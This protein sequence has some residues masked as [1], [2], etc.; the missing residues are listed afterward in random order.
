MKIIKCIVWISLL[1][2]QLAFSQGVVSQFTDAKGYYAR[3]GAIGLNQSHL[4]IGNHRI[5]TNKISIGLPGAP[6]PISPTLKLNPLGGNITM[7]NTITDF[8]ALTIRSFNE[9][10]LSK[11][12]HFEGDG[13][14]VTDGKLY[15]QIDSDNNEGGQI[16]FYNHNETLFRINEVGNSYLKGNFHV[17]GK[18][19]AD[20]VKS[21]D[22]HTIGF[23]DVEALNDFGD[24]LYTSS[25]GY[26]YGDN[27]TGFYMYQLGAALNLPHQ[28]KITKIEVIYKD[29]NNEY[30]FGIELR[31]INNFSNSHTT[32]Y[33]RS[34]T[35]SYS[36]SSWQKFSNNVDIDIDNNNSIYY[37]AVVSGDWGNNIFLGKSRFIIH[38]KDICD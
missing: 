8:A 21:S 25:N 28:A 6:P 31:K 35:D 3:F 26:A 32:I 1:T 37:F 4:L 11:D 36:S 2:S 14:I 33:N 9:S 7:G 16:Y 30:E 22:I 20:N 13:R 17:D 19:T 29:N 10:Y 5:Q 23:S 34:T 38:I 18:I 27:A 15:F 12:I 24:E